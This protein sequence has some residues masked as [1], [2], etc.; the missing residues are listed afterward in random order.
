[1]IVLQVMLRLL[2]THLGR[3][4]IYTMCILIQERWAYKLWGMFLFISVNSAGWLH[5][6]LL[7]GGGSWPLLLAANS[8]GWP[9]SLNSPSGSRSSGQ[10]AL[11]LRG[12][13][14]YVSMSMWGVRRV[15]SLD[16]TFASVLPSIK[17]VGVSS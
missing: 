2:G 5:S 10:D 13:V 15:E 4:A 17:Q 3:S 16:L 9:Y 7:I 12:A 1:M 11:L 8:G 6:L 14:F